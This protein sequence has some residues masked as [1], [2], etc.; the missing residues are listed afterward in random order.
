MKTSYREISK[1]EFEVSVTLDDGEIEIIGILSCDYQGRWHCTKKFFSTMGGNDTFN[2]IKEDE[3]VT[4]GRLLM[5]QWNLYNNRR[6]IKESWAEASKEYAEKTY[7][8]SLP[9]VASKN[10]TSRKIYVN[11]DED[12]DDFDFDSFWDFGEEEDNR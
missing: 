1:T 12:L 4:A 11:S 7:D 2:S 3:M 8:L 6:K 10:T 5:A 9:S